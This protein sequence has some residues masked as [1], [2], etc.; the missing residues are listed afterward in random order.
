MSGIFH[1]DGRDANGHSIS[2]D[3]TVN[4]VDDVISYLQK[5]NII[6]INIQVVKKR[7]IN[8]RDLSLITIG[9]KEVP[10]HDIMNFCRQLAALNGAGVPLIKAIKQLTQSASS[11]VLINILAT[12]ADDIAAGFNLAN[13]LKKHPNAFPPLVSNTIEVGENTG[14]LNEV[15]LQLST[16]LETTI[17]NRRNL[18]SAVRYP[19]LV[20]GT[21]VAAMIIVD[22]F[23][24]PKFAALFA[25]FHTQLPLPT[26]IIMA[27]ST[28]MVN[29]WI[30]LIV[31]AFC[32]I[33]GTRQLLKI[34]KVIYFW[35]KEKLFLP[36]I[37]N[38]QRRILLSQFAWT[39]SLVLR[40]GLPIIKGLVLAS[41]STGNFYF[42]KQLLV[43]SGAI[44]H[45]E[46][47]SQ[48]AIKSNLFTPMVVQMIEVGE[49]SGKL[50]ELIGDI[51]KY[52]DEEVSYDMKRLNE[53]IEPILL[54]VIGS[55]VLV[56]ALAVYLPMWDLI[57]V[58]KK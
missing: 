45:G 26:R 33:I 38:I 14:H 47:F 4:T 32:I 29:H 22:F 1:Y 17:I 57:E 37:G 20:V 12:V 24:M 41:N 53:S 11:P 18:V 46:T 8:L 35:D 58:I 36:V 25:H 28:F 6:P 56:L 13:S 5:R 50:D 16:Y 48:A 10:L 2:G 42:S 34:Q 31:V 21:I 44:Q 30:V 27:S 23:V 7:M 3:L 54:G 39:F 19:L 15:L 40:S 51:A 49:E 9:K 55:M 52:Y 43:M